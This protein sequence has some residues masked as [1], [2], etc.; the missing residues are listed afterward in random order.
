MVVMAKA[1]PPVDV[2]DDRFGA[3]YEK[4]LAASMRAIGKGG[5]DSRSLKSARWQLLCVSRQGVSTADFGAQKHDWQQDCH[6][7]CRAGVTAIVEE[8]KRAI[9]AME[10]D[11]LGHIGDAI[12]WVRNRNG[13]ALATRLQRLS[14]HRNAKCHPDN[15][16][17]FLE[18]LHNF[19][20][21]AGTSTSE[22]EAELQGDSSSLEDDGAGDDECGGSSSLTCRDGMDLDDES[23]AAGSSG[24]VEK[25]QLQTAT[26]DGLQQQVS[27]KDGSTLQKATED[28]MQLHKATGG[29]L[30]EATD[31]GFDEA[32][33]DFSDHDGSDLEGDSGAKFDE[34]KYIN[35]NLVAGA[36]VRVFPKVEDHH[37]GL[38][39]FYGKCG[40]LKRSMEDFAGVKFDDGS[41]Q[42]F[43]LEELVPQYGEGA[44]G[45]L[46]R[47]S[48]EGESKEGTGEEKGKAQQQKGQE[49]ADAA[50]RCSR[51]V[52]LAGASGSF[53]GAAQLEEE[54]EVPEEDKEDPGA[55]GRYR[56]QKGQRG[57]ASSR[58]AVAELETVGRKGQKDQEGEEGEKG[59]GKKREAGRVMEEI[60]KKTVDEEEAEKEQENNDRSGFQ[61]QQAGTAGRCRCS[62]SRQVGAKSCE[63]IN[64]PREVSRTID[65]NG[66]K[67]DAAGRQQARYEILQK[68]EEK[69]LQDF[70]EGTEYT[71][72]GNKVAKR[73]QELRAEAANLKAVSK[74]AMRN[75]S[76]S[77]RLG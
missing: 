48:G 12:R 66:H 18:E 45:D 2:V 3:P 67:A 69:V 61:E 6:H 77:G 28:G 60:Y 41:I 15:G 75:S 1:A 32:C 42:I 53:A 76:G 16:K 47:N 20:A 31:D 13:A 43:E 52:Q 49:K 9:I 36:R 55:A 44:G 62:F 40:V 70:V 50:G 64:C 74:A 35:K 63:K 57:Q 27:K 10:P 72:K 29:G 5:L 21:V 19:L 22:P 54:E 25:Q 14:Q 39:E 59:G 34:G 30:Q 4:W 24:E 11:C 7:G 68:M 58:R 56:R 33:K 73:I 8:A 51:Q 38:S 71:D 26:E 37:K 65:L 17:G 23:S 46:Q